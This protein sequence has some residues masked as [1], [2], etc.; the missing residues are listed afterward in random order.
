MMPNENVCACVRV[1]S[2][3]RI[4]FFYFISPFGKKQKAFRVFLCVRACV[5]VIGS[6]DE[7]E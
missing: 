6:K 7:M 3:V 4:T 2:N 1:S 5:C